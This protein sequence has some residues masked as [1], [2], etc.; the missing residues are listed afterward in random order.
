MAPG[1]F[2]DRPGPATDPGDD[3]LPLEVDTL[4]LVDDEG[5]EVGAV[6]ANLAVCVNISEIPLL[7]S[8]DMLASGLQG[9]EVMPV[10]AGGGVADLSEVG[11]DGTCATA[12][13]AHA[14]P[15]QMNKGS[16]ISNLPLSDALRSCAI[17]QPLSCVVRSEC[18]R[19]QGRG[20][21]SC[22]SFCS[23]ASD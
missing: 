18:S 16:F 2:V 15:I 19:C 13:D 11:F 1:G 20:G 8:A 12:V 21:A 3:V 5:D 4:E 17:R 6:C 9:V 22:G 10:G 7:P 23:S 14:M